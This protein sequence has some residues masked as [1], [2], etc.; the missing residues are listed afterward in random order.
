MD[1]VRT[2]KE[3][4]DNQRA[5]D[6]TNNLGVT[7]EYPCGAVDRWVIDM[8]IVCPTTFTSTYPIGAIV[9]SPT[10]PVD[11]NTWFQCNG[12]ALDQSTYSAL[13]SILGHSWARFKTDGVKLTADSIT[14]GRLFWTTPNAGTGSYFTHRDS[15][16]TAVSTDCITWTPKT[17]VGGAITGYSFISDSDAVWFLWQQSG[18]TAAI[19]KRSVDQGIT[20]VTPAA[21]FPFAFTQIHSNGTHWLGITEAGQKVASSADSGSTWTD[22]GAVLP[23]SMTNAKLLWDG[24]NWVIFEEVTGTT[25][26]GTWL[27]YKTSVSNGSSGWT[28]VTIPPEKYGAVAGY[29]RD[30]GEIITVSGHMCQKSTGQL[31]TTSKQVSIFTPH[32]ESVVWNGFVY[33]GFAELPAWDSYGGTRPLNGGVVLVSKDGLIWNPTPFPLL[34]GNVNSTIFVTSHR[35]AKSS[36]SCVNPVTGDIGVVLHNRTDSFSN[37]SARHTALLKFDFTVASQFCVPT[38]PGTVNNW[39]RAL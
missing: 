31:T 38:L 8:D 19:N 10:A 12:Q 6:I 34:H 9:T 15:G 39:I 21:G 4:E 27:V 30:T 3:K 7:T 35:F 13:Y 29:R 11:G 22:H 32:P 5:F 37:P 24:T 14:S 23:T 26:S 16:F 36:N 17:P 1:V 20:W 25:S 2:V 18:S 28:S 33:V